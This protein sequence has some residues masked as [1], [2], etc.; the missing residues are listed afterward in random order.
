MLTQYLNPRGVAAALVVVGLRQQITKLRDI[1]ENCRV[2]IF[3]VI[4]L[5]EFV[6]IIQVMFIFK[7]VF[8][9]ESVILFE[10]VIIF[11]VV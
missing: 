2:F 5:F 3:E 1:V 4:F 9:F 10:I 8:I 6:F 11:K 7:T